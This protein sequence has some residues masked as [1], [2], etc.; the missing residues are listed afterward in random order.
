MRPGGGEAGRG[1]F[2]QDWLELDGLSHLSKDPETFAYFSPDIG[3]QAREETLSLFEYLV[4]DADADFRTLLT[5]RATFVN[6]RLAALYGIPSVAV[7]GFELVTLPDD[8]PRAGLL[9]HASVLSLHASPN[10]S[11]PTLRGL[12]IRE[13]L[14]CQNMPSPP[15]NVD[16][17]IPESSEDAPT[18]RDRLQIHLET[19]AALDVMRSP[20]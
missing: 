3:Q 9:G 2:A 20:T 8:G 16:T 15:A 18:M 5:T 4:L 1:A 13:R 10:R 19:P 12:F 17:T 7:E 6:R 11:S 14:L